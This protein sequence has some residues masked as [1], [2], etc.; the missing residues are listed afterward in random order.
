MIKLG[1]ISQDT[2]CFKDAPTT[3]STGLEDMPI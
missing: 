2:R 1:K 3:E